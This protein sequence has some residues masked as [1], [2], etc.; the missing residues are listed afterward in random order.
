M[1]F[2]LVR[3]DVEFNGDRIGST[4]SLTLYGWQPP[5]G[6]CAV[7][8]FEVWKANREAAVPYS[9][10]SL[11]RRRFCRHEILLPR[12]RRQVARLG[13]RGRRNVC[14]VPLAIELRVG[15]YVTEGAG[16]SDVKDAMD[17]LIDP[18]DMSIVRVAWRKLRGWSL[19][20]WEWTD[21]IM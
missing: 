1:D 15:V 14:R 9:T 13:T 4:S 16:E 5:V 17:R 18:R 3:S 8:G 20:K 7:W 11:L 6:N 2:A 12:G 10:H 19:P 21:S